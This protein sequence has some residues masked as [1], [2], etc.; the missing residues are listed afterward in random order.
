MRN[1]CTAE[2]VTVLPGTPSDIFLGRSPSDEDKRIPSERC[3]PGSCLP[4]RKQQEDDEADRSR[5]HRNNNIVLKKTRLTNQNLA[6]LATKT[7]PFYPSKN[8]AIPLALPQHYPQ[9]QPWVGRVH[10][11]TFALSSAHEG[12]WTA[13]PFTAWYSH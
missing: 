9:R 10:E 12:G 5:M 2:H 6:Y 8:A 3:A 7:T 13:H 1:E 4:K 11:F